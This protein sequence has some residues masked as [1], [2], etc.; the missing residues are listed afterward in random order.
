MTT[1]SG[2]T[3]HSGGSRYDSSS[4]GGP[5]PGAG[6]P[7][8]Y[9]EVPPDPPPAYGETPPEPGA[10]RGYGEP[11]S[12]PPP[13]YGET[14]PETGPGY[15]QAPPD[16]GYPPTPPKGSY[17]ADPPQP[18]GYV[19]EGT[20]P[21][22]P[23][24]PGP[25]LP[26]EGFGPEDPGYPGG[27]TEPQ[28]PTS[29]S[30][31]ASHPCPPSMTCD[32]G[33]IDDL[34]CEA[35][36]VKAES[37]ALAA[38]AKALADRRTA[39]ETARSEYTKAR[40]AANQAVKD[41]NRRVD[42]LLDDTRCLPLNKDEFDCIDKAFGQVLDCLRDCRGETGCCVDEGCGFADQTWTVGQ[43]DDLRVRVEKVEK[44]FDEVL[45]KEPAALTARVEALTKQVDELAEALKA[46]PR[47]EVNRL[48]ARAKRLRWL[49][50]DVWGGFADVN[51]FQNCLCRG[52]T[53][54]LKGR[55]WLAQLAGKKAY[56]DCQDASKQRRCT[57]LRDN[58]V[59]ET[60]ATQLVLCPPEPACGEDH[61]ESD[62]SAR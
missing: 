60:L 43:M 48:Y 45:V 33:A 22:G 24:A 55:G 56:Q 54:S 44:C 50:D 17:G 20:V 49:L 36:G 42:D 6:T 29:A 35:S 31:P 11:S 58:M 4:V 46:D 27:K 32:T 26:T 40:E 38:V 12:D 52:L 51:E 18:P 9:G 5:E 25:E 19:E 8:S 21:S 47:E 34:Q 57:W 23:G 62:A 13:A 61:S 53:C 41:L 37:D 30:P 16:A 39:F 2:K 28:P 15:G 14:P 59:D 7:A 10:V 1:S 3:P